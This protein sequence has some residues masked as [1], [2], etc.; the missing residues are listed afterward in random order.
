MRSGLTR[1]E[2][3]TYW[4]VGQDHGQGECHRNAPRPELYKPAMSRCADV[5]WPPT[6]ADDGCG[7]GA[8]W[9]G[10]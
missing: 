10:E 1:C 9:N 6:M 5:F 7:Q 4:R 2:D 8:R 3:C